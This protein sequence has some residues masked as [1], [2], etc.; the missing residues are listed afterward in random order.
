MITSVSNPKMKHVM[1]LNKKS[2]TRYQER[3]FVVEGLKMCMEVSREMIREMYVSERFI[4]NGAN[5]ERLKGYNYEVV[6]DVVF[7][8]ISDTKTPQGIL[9]LVQMPEY[10]LGDLLGDGFFAEPAVA[11]EPVSAGKQ[12]HLLILESIQDPGNL[13]T[14]MRTGEGAGITGVIMNR[15]TAD[16]FHPK[17][18][19]STMGSLFRVPF[20][21]S[22]NLQETIAVLKGKGIA[23]YAAHLDGK[24]CYDEPDYT[25]PCGFLVGNEGNGLSPEIAAL[26]DAYVRIPM[27]GS[28]ESLNAAVASALLMYE[29]SRQRRKEFYAYLV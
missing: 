19:R 18:I 13:G 20:Y 6:K 1:Q 26:A 29:T 15:T 12:P 16:I 23:L 27:E 28:V 24:V 3:V 4:A 25:V 22:D 8:H 14:M 17:T 2:K 7:S 21:I 9:C 5:R 10:A 11:E